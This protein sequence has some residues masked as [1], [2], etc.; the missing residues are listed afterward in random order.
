M[1][2]PY[3]QPQYQNYFPANYQPVYQQPMQQSVQQQNQPI[4]T[5]QS[6][7]PNPV[8]N[9]IIWVDNEREAALFPVGPNNA[10]ALWESSGKRAYMKKADATGKPIMTVYDLVERSETASGDTQKQGDT[11]PA[12]ALKSDLSVVVEALKGIDG[13]IASITG[14]IDTM[15]GDLYGVAGKRK[16]VK[17]QEGDDE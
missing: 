11:L 4:Q 8:S 16:T 2:Y 13:V 10:V 9:G 6:F 1:P 12:Y 14:D 17:K 3:Y 5:A 7:N 15:K